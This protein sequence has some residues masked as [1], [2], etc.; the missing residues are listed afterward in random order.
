MQCLFSWYCIW[1]RN[2]W[3]C[4]QYLFHLYCSGIRLIGWNVEMRDTWECMKLL[5]SLYY[6]STSLNAWSWY[7]RMYKT[8]LRL[9]G[10]WIR[11]N[12]YSRDAWVLREWMLIH[13]SLADHISFI[14]YNLHNECMLA[15]I[16]KDL[17]F[18]CLS[19]MK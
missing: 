7:M 8:L 6:I 16:R 14:A 13:S 3:E 5:L 9:Y 4:M 12:E 18:L 10:I 17:I 19:S 15:S 1:M 11:L 2:T